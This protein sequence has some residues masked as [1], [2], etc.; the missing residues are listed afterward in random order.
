MVSGNL[1]STF[2]FEAYKKV[3]IIFYLFLSS[4]IET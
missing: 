1:F 4:I 3:D 2:P